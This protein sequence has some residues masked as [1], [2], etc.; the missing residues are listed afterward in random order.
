LH[1]TKQFNLDTLVENLIEQSIVARRNSYSPYSK[2]KVGAALLCAD[3]TIYTGANVECASYSLTICAERV[4][5]SKA[6]A[7]GKREFKTI[8][9]AIN[10]DHIAYPCGA[11]LQFMA[12]FCS[13]LEII[14]VITQQTYRRYILKDL[15]PNN[16]AL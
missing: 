11:C 7:D 3:G 1:I 9:I 10:K 16:F 8:A 13:D 14:L 12:E 4:A 15:L 6:V 2:F 5:F